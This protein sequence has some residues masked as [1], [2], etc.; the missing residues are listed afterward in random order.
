MQGISNNL[1]GID[2]SE[3]M[4]SK[5]NKLGVYD[6]LIAGDIVEKLDLSK[7]KYDLF[8]ALD[9]FIYIGEITSMLNAVKKCAN[10]KNSFFIFSIEIFKGEGYSLLKSSRYAHSDSY[11]L[12]VASNGFELVDSENVKLRKEGN[13]W[14]DGKIYILKV[15]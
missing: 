3:N 11:I 8:I 5:A 10:K 1:T 4:I 2:I 14:I 7:E 15:S 12:E 6:S 13:K 9:V